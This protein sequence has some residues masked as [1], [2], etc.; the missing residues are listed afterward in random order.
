MLA[1]R[2]LHKSFGG[3][4]AVRNLS[5]EL[6]AGEML[7]LIGPNG[8]GKS[9]CFNLLNGQ[10][11]PDRGTVRLDGALISGLKPQRIA[12]QGLARTFQI[13]AT[14]ASMTVIQNI[15]MA[16]AAHHKRVFSFWRPLPHYYYAEAMALLQQLDLQHLAD[17]A[18]SQLAYGDVKRLE[19]GVALASEPRVLLMDEPTAGMATAER[20]AL[21]RL[22][23]E[24]VRRRGMSV[25]FTEHSM[26]V[27]FE[28]A[29]RVLVMARGELIAQG[30]VA[31]IRAHPEVQKV[32]FGSGSS[33]SGLLRG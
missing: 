13:A 28:C 21:M 3:N 26:D 5:F 10:L 29:D 7:A 22:V 24:L 23:Q 4:Q 2:N 25:L 31:D 1:I 18:S 14:F 17:S 15:Q 20:R 6:K 30:A 32:Y 27:V 11:N 12:E 16:M 9:T 8:A 33:F 19:L